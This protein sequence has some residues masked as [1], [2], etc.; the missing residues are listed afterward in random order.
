MANSFSGDAR[1][2]VLY[3]FESGA[4]G[5]DDIGS[6]DLTN[7][8]A[9]VDTGD[10]QEG[11]GS[12]EFVN[13]ESDYLVI[14]DASLPTTFPFQSGGSEKC[15]CFGVWFKTTTVSA[16]D[17]GI[18]GKYSLN[19]KRSFLIS[20]NGAYLR[21]NK[22]YNNGAGGTSINLYT[23]QTGRWYH[24]GGWYDAANY[25]GYLRL[26][27]DTAG[28]VVAED[29]L[30]FSGGTTDPGTVNL[31]GPLS[32][33]CFYDATDTP[34]GFWDGNIDELVIGAGK[35]S[36]HEI[37]L[38][39]QGNFDGS[40]DGLAFY[41]IDAEIEYRE[42]PQINV[43]Q[44]LVEVLYT[45]DDPTQKE[46][47]GQIDIAV[48]PSS[49]SSQHFQYAGNI[50][51]SIDASAEDYLYQP[52]GQYVYAGSIPI[53]VVPSA[54]IDRVFSKKGNIGISIGLAGTY[55][56]PTRFYSGVI[57][58][59]IDLEGIYGTPVPGW[60]KATGYGLV[61]VDDLDEAP[62]YWVVEDDE[63]TL[64]LTDTSTFALYAES[65]MELEG[66]VLVEGEPDLEFFD[67]TYPAEITF[68]PVPGVV[69]GLKL[70]FAF[71]GFP[72][73]VIEFP[74]V[75]IYHPKLDLEGGV[76][77][78]GWVEF[79]FVD[80]AEITDESI[81]FTTKGG[82]RVRGAPVFEFFN[83]YDPTEEG[84]SDILDL[85][86]GVIVG[87]FNRPWEDFLFF[88]PSTAWGVVTQ[89]ETY[90][91]VY[92]TGDI[93]FDFYPDAKT[94]Q[95]EINRLGVAVGITVEIGVVEPPVLQLDLDGGVVVE[96]EVY[97][98]NE[99]FE[100]WA[101]TGFRFSPSM[102]SNFPFNSY[103]AVNGTVLGANANGI[104]IVE[105]E[106][107]DGAVIHPGIR[108]GPWNFGV[109]NL[110]RIRAVYPGNAGSPELKV[111]SVTQGLESFVGLYRDRFNIPTN[112]Q[113]RLL[114]LELSDFDE[115]SQFEIIPVVLH[116]K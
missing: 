109:D 45:P 34:T 54:D 72:P 29:H 89:F 96:G 55:S 35:V 59:T 58:F 56:Y 23:L 83:I 30:M 63:I 17:Y 70:D 31:A 79:D 36:P 20:R 32:V 14:A 115:V 101:L 53:S 64:A 16:G 69:V 33:G 105:G 62:P 1:W 26:W 18:F 85:D 27:D 74:E 50:G 40:S 6:Y 106:D 107:D 28:A 44:I 75:D 73:R 46:Y 15:V 87:G 104:Y 110:K 57:S 97:E 80:P 61:E 91:T 81:A 7:N 78:W 51:I 102:Y 10:Y 25:M 4:I 43:S 92:A 82:V 86:G 108:M 112:I 84:A 37:D 111:T 93:E 22:S 47:N 42:T 49:V 12:A 11:A 41:Q 19:S 116:K 52:P 48:T 71:V 9:V 114:I 88:D 99:I 77:A 66:G 2:L 21:F 90:G 76:Y 98:I 13:S 103:A 68:E 39:R 94:S 67:P 38:I 24:L 65:S 8:G 3:S 100:T 95:F 5:Q 60:D 113:D